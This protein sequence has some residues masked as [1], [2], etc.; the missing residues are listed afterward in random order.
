MTAGALWR[1]LQSRLWQRNARKIDLTISK[2]QRQIAEAHL[3]E[4]QARLDRLQTSVDVQTERRRA[5]QK[6]QP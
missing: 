3:R 5:Q 4:L 2:A 1:W 6:E